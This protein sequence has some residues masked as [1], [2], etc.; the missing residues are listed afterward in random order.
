RLLHPTSGHDEERLHEL[1]RVDARLA[2][3][4]AERLAAAETAGAI[5]GEA[6]HRGGTII[7]RV[8]RAKPLTMRVVRHSPPSG[9]GRL[10]T[11][12]ATPTRD[13]K[14]TRLNSSH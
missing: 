2:H 5:G 10:L 6:A 4:A 8:P 1:G 3:Q 9:R 11:V 14:S 13:R 7:S 12:R